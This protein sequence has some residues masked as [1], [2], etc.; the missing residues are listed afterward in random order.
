MIETKR[1]ILRPF[2]PEDVY[3][4]HEIFSDEETMRQCEPPYSMDKTR[5]FLEAFCI[6]KQ[7][8]LACE[9]KET[10]KVIGYI[11]YKSFGEG[12]PDG[13]EDVYEVG[14]IFNRAY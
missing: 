11:L 2:T 1:T 4:L 10:G 5:A 9:L 14:W 12:N 6:K 3:D 7:G 13:R 8:A